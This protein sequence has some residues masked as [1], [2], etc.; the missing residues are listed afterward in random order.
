MGVVPYNSVGGFST[1]LTLTNVIDSLGNITGVGATFSGDIAVNGGDIT[2]TSTSATLFN[3]NA[4]TLD[5]LNT[6]SSG[7]TLNIGTATT[8]SGKKTINIGSNIGGGG[9]SVITLG[10]L[11]SSSKVSIL[12]GITIGGVGGAPVSVNSSLFDVSALSTFSGAVSMTHISS[13]TGLAS[14]AGGI[15]AAGG[16]TFASNVQANGYI[17]T[18]NARSWFL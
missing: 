8:Y 1:G 11:S 16:I 18:S 3:A 10:S 14:F 4:T 6:Q 2:T 15:S 12:G 7:F 17:L 13:H 9:S 5:I